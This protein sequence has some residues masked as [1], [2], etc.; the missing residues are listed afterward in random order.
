MR[1]GRPPHPDVLTPREWEV[2]D[3][4]REG[5][6]NDEI[7]SRLGISY[8]G[9]RYHVAEILSKLG[10]AS[11]EEAAA[12]SPED[13]RRKRFAGVVALPLLLHR[14]RVSG[15]LKLLG[16]FVLGG[17]AILV[18]LFAAGVIV[19]RSPRRAAPG[20]A[21]IATVAPTPDFP[22]VML[23]GPYMVHPAGTANPMPSKEIDIGLTPDEYGQ[24]VDSVEAARTS[25]LF[26][27]KL[28]DGDSVVGATSDGKPSEL[29]L[30][31]TLSTPD[32]S[33][34]IVR[35]R[36]N[37]MPIDVTY[38]PSVYEQQLFIAGVG[39]G[40]ALA[41]TAGPRRPAGDCSSFRGRDRHEHLWCGAEPE[42]GL[43]VCQ[44]L[45]G[46]E[47]PRP[48][49]VAAAADAHDSGTAY[50]ESPASRDLAT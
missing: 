27:T 23:R 43:D 11:R 7:A 35:Q 10:V 47:R 15:A 29:Y 49:D 18:G 30:H 34:E 21:A 46:R 19:T 48:L 4:L 6:S 39:P 44:T 25:S 2:L 3:L 38:D 5:L 31:L 28:P 9:A 37:E 40:T 12:W 36:P 8:N 41:P 20:G 42:L 17:V 33:V 16:V 45:Q 22:L 32:G 13:V 14:L 26:P 1:R 50:V 24:P